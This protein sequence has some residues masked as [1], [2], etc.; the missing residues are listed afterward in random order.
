MKS[1]ICSSPLAWVGWP[2]EDRLQ[3]VMQADPQV[4]LEEEANAQQ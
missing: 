4:L 2:N 3:K 1:A